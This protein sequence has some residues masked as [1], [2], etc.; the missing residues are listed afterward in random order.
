MAEF[1][2]PVKE[3]IRSEFGTIL[4]DHACESKTQDDLHGRHRRVFNR[5]KDNKKMRC[6]VCKKEEFV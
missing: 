6:T 1:K 2:K 5:M 4:R 3:K